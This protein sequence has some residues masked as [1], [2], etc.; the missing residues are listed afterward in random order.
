MNRATLTAFIALAL[1]LP[2]AWETNQDIEVEQATADA[3]ADRGAEH[4]LL[5]GDVKF[6]EVRP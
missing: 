3:V 6:A 5:V 1:I 4:A 2:T